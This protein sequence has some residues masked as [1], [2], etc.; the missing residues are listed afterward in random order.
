MGEEAQCHP[1]AKI[2]KNS[3]LDQACELGENAANKAIFWLAPKER[4]L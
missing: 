3:G 2:I 4:D 1:Q